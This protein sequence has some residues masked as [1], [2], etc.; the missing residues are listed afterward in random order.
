MAAAGGGESSFQGFGKQ[1][2]NTIIGAAGTSGIKLDT[3]VV[4]SNLSLRGDLVA[5]Q[6]GYQLIGQ[7]ACQNVMVF[8]GRIHQLGKSNFFIHH[9]VQ[10]KNF[11][12]GKLGTYGTVIIRNSD[13]PKDLPFC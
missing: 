4:Q 1:F 7:K 9:I 6:T 2:V 11:R 12:V 8:T 5:D 13:S 3:P 10:L